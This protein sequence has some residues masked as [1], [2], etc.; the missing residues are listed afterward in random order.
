MKKLF[1]SLMLM[2][3]ALGV[4]VPA[5]AVVVSG[6]T[7]T[8]YIAGD[9]GGTN[10]APV[11]TFDGGSEF[12]FRDGLLLTFDESETDLGSGNS[13]ITLSVDANG[14]LFPVA[15]EGAF[16]G[17]GIFNDPLDLDTLLALYDARVTLRDIDGTILFA[18]DNIAGL[19]VNNPP[20]DGSLPT[21][22]NVFNISDIGGTGVASITFDFYVTE[23]LQ[24]EVPE[25]GSVLLCGLG[26][27]A[28]VAVR[29]QR[30]PRA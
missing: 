18:S 20:W 24:G 16:L 9:G 23:N 4:A 14:D 7:Y 21:Q 22:Q 15:G 26:L 25:P 13:L 5:S 17:I 11:L 19:A 6:S 12:I 1:V 3:A 2:V 27:L 10:I 8:M 28:I 29:R 30:K